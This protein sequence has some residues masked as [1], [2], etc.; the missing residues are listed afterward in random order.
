MLDPCYWAM[1]YACP[2]LL[3]GLVLS[4]QAATAPAA[5]STEATFISATAAMKTVL[6]TMWNQATTGNKGIIS[7]TAHKLVGAVVT[8]I[9]APILFYKGLKYNDLFIIAFSIVLFL[10][11][12]YWL[13]TSKPN[14][15]IDK[16]EETNNLDEENIQN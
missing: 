14:S 4:I 6:Q 12:L 15:Y 8:P 1:N 11:D 3:H 7:S 5:A 10:W 16:S 13:V 9:V 2:L